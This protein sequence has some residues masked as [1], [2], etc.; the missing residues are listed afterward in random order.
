M[1]N[2]SNA[3]QD[4]FSLLLSAYMRALCEDMEGIAE[5]FPRVG[6]ARKDLAAYMALKPN[7]AFR[8]FRPEVLSET[9]EAGDRICPR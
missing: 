9:V 3:Q 8:R 6:R 1:R 7:V 5:E 4:R 2:A